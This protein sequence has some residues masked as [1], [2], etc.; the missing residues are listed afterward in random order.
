ML[1]Y[2][3]KKFL[4]IL[5]TFYF[6]FISVGVMYS[7]HYCGSRASTSVWGISISKERACICSKNN[8]KHKKNCCKSD[9]KFFKA[10]TGNSKNQTS[11][12]LLK[13]N[14]STCLL[15]NHLF[16]SSNIA[17]AELTGFQLIR[18]PPFQKNPLFIQYRS[19]II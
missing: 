2:L 16:F 11:F 14:F 3:M 13:L 4:T 10:K 18:P 17:S 9:T 12:Q 1:I 15:V 5:F 7:K 19:I 8:F 6:F